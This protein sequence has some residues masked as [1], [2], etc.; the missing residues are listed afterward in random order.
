MIM[1]IKIPSPI[2]H[3][4]FKVNVVKSEIY[5]NQQLLLTVSKRRL[6]QLKEIK[7]FIEVSTYQHYICMIHT[8]SEWILHTINFIFI[9]RNCI[10]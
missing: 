7:L 10:F 3:Q 2:N 9:W 4:L 5:I 1:K 8:V 6:N